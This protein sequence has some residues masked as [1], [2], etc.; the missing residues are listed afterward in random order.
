[1]MLNPKLKKLKSARFLLL[2]LSGVWAVPV[3][4]ALKFLNR[5]FPL[6]LVC[7]RSDRIGHF[8]PDGAEALARIALDE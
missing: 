3:L 7:I 1:M 4:F 2:L 5:F 6:E 8:L